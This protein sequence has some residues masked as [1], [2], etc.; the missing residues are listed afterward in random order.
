MYK[1]IQLVS[2][3]YKAVSYSSYRFLQTIILQ[4]SIC[5]ISIYF[6]IKTNGLLWKCKS[7]QILLIF[8]RYTMGGRKSILYTLNK[9]YEFII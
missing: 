6:L 4:K 5:M 9:G 1:Y 3:D 8:T 2:I 7:L